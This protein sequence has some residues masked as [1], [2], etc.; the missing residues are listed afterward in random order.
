MDQANRKPRL[1]C[2]SSAEPDDVTPAVNT[3]TKKSTSP[4]AMQ[5]G[6]CLPWCLQN[7]LGADPS[8]DPVW[9][10]KWDISDAFHQCLLLPADICAFMYVVPPPSNRHIN[11]PVN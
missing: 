2:N 6:S 4:N 5:F 10:S 3:S 11:T 1:I 8:D 7:I 9:L